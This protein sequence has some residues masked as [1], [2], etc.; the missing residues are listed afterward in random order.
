MR[1]GILCEGEK[2]DEPVLRLLLEH[3]FPAHEFLIRGVSKAVIFSGGDIELAR[4]FDQGAERALIVWDLLPHT[5]QLAVQV[6]WNERPSRREQRQMLLEL[7]C[8]SELLPDHLRLQ[9]HFYAH[10]YNF[11]PF[12]ESSVEHP[13]NGVHYFRLV[14]VCYTADGWLLADEGLLTSLANKSGPAPR[15]NKQHPDRCTNPIDVLT[16][17]FSQSRNRRLKFFN[18]AD[19]NIVIAAEY[20][21][22]DRIK[23]I[24]RRS[25]SFRYLVEAIEGW[26]QV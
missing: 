23:V 6:Q 9:A 20:R 8:K 17:Y 1:I 15:C 12:H 4:L 11:P 19:H 25:S 21:D 22:Q 5:H 16:N 14:C 3:V 24:R 13:N 7:L 26:G 18:K 2:T 10:R